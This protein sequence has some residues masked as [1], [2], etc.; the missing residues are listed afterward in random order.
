MNLL[1]AA[2]FEADSFRPLRA[3]ADRLGIKVDTHYKMTN[4]IH[5]EVFQLIDEQYFDLLLVGAGK[6]LYTGSLL[7]NLVGV[8][9]ALSP[10]KLIGSLTAG[11]PL[12]PANDQID[13]KARQFAEQASADV[14]ILLDSEFSGASKIFLPLFEE[15]DLFLLDYAKRFIVNASSRVSVMDP[16]GILSRAP[17]IKSEIAETNYRYTNAITIM[18]D[19]AIGKDFLARQDL[20]LISYEGWK[21]LINSKSS[22]IQGLPGTLI[23]K[24]NR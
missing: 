21:G 2:D 11:R 14:G 16:E 5:R 1:N 22:W 6:S 8:T 4:E 10:E 7:G 19:K 15:W 3:E 24:K 18:H 17:R 12:F 13:E 23:L 9:K 20:M